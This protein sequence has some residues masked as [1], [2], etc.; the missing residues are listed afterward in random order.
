[1]SNAVPLPWADSAHP[2]PELQRP[3]QGWAIPP[4]LWSPSVCRKGSVFVPI[5]NLIP[6]LFLTHWD[7]YL[8]FECSNE[9]CLLTIFLFYPCGF[10]FEGCS[11]VVVRWG[12]GV[13]V[14]AIPPSSPETSKLKFIIGV[15]ASIPFRIFIPTLCYCKIQILKASVLIST[16][17]FL[18]IIMLFHY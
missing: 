10:V 11:V 18:K 2:G 1:M 8:D 13:F 15:L 12:W 5:M 6:L 16:S 4:E 17:H 14:W 7:V 3:L 9:Q